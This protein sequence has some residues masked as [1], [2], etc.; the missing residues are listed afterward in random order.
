MIDMR[1]AAIIGLLFALAAMGYLLSMSAK[2]TQEALDLLDLEAKAL[3][4]QTAKV[5]EYEKMINRDDRLLDSLLHGTWER[6]CIYELVP[7]EL[8]ADGSVRSSLI[9]HCE[10]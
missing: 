9:Q 4:V 10:E 7:G 1:D 3:E 8:L 5:I 6:E 2:Q